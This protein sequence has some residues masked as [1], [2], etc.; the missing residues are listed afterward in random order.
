MA[1]TETFLFAVVAI[2]VVCVTH[3][4][5]QATTIDSLRLGYNIGTNGKFLVPREP[6]EQRMKEL[7]AEGK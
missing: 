1:F 2:I 4:N 7:G 5:V 3:G 6:L